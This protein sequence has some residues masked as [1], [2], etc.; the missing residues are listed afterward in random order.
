VKSHCDTPQHFC[1]V[2]RQTVTDT[3]TH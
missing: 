1:S 2:W 3:D